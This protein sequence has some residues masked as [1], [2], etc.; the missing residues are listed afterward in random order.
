MLSNKKDIV[1]MVDGKLVTKG[2]KENFFGDVNMFGYEISPNLEE[3]KSTLH[4]HITYIGKCSRNFK[5]CNV[6]DQYEILL[7]L[8]QMNTQLLCK[9][10]SHNTLQRK[11][12]L[13][14]TSR[15]PSSNIPDKA[16]SSC[17]TEI[18]TS[19]MWMRNALKQNVKLCKLMATHQNNLHLFSTVEQENVNNLQNARFLYDSA[20]VSQHINSRKYPNLI[21]K[22]SD[23][24]YELV[25]E[26]YV[27]SERLF[28]ALGLNGVN[29]MKM[30]FKQFVKDE[31]TEDFLSKTCYSQSKINSQITLNCIV[32]PSILPS[33]AIFY[34]EG[35]YFLDGRNKINM[36][37]ST[38]TG[39]IR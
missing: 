1:L 2:L 27:M 13:N 29:A 34:K 12:L 18:Y 8:L 24:W 7:D 39:I 6:A 4:S 10:C 25:K 5:E 17:K 9:I 36:L 14:L 23:G 21:K 3:L 15:D 33:Y 32:T 16:I 30:H 20:Y 38:H 37:C 28:S 35:C 19:N 11:K 31:T 22:Y 26:S